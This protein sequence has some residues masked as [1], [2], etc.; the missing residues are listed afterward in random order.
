MD[1]NIWFFV[2]SALS[3]LIAL[4]HT[5][6]GGA[7]ILVPLLKSSTPETPKATHF[8]CWHMVTFVLF[9]MAAA[10]LWSGLAPTEQTPAIIATLFS[11]VF[12]IWGFG[13]AAL[14]GQNAVKQMPQGLMFLAPL[15]CGLA[16]IAQ[17]S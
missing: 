17:N 12:A 6:A 5:V 3:L 11:G 14:R 8:Y 13:A 4:V 9:F 10:F 1:A 7:A 15:A 2:A 16:A